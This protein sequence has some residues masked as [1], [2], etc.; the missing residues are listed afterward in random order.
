MPIYQ[1]LSND[2]LLSCCL[3]GFTQNN[4][5]SLNAIM[6]SIAPKTSLSGKILVDIAAD[7]A[8]CKFNDGFTSIMEI[9]QVLNLSMSYNYYNFYTEADAKRVKAAKRS[10]SDAAQGLSKTSRKEEEDANIDL[11][12]QLY[13]AGI[14]E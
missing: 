9:M 4:N 8:V 6:W 5:E 11:E 10:M 7:I 3:G 12:G 13:G 14:A 1:D 2:G